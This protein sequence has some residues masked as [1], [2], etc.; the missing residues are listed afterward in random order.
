MQLV[1]LVDKIPVK[2]T[3]VDSL[4]LYKYRNEV[5]LIT[6]LGEEHIIGLTAAALCAVH[7]SPLYSDLHFLQSAVSCEVPVIACN[8]KQAEELLK[9]AALYADPFS[10][11]S[12]A[13]QLMLVYKDEKK[14]TELVENGKR[15]PSS[16]PGKTAWE[17]I[18]SL[19]GAR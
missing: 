10:I 15:L 9:D 6:G 19:A 18:L 13:A 8:T 3:F 16:P 1:L 11:D 17:M 14:Q 7:L 5:K 2:D 4:R 12:I